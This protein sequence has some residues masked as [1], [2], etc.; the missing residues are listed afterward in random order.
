VCKKCSLIPLCETLD[1]NCVTVERVFV[2]TSVGNFLFLGR[3]LWSR[4][5]FC[6]GT[7]VSAFFSCFC[8]ELTGRECF[9]L[10]GSGVGGS[11]SERS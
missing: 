10:F 9:L 5:L 7:D 11:V 1:V 4:N 2:I 8:L 6:L 3:F